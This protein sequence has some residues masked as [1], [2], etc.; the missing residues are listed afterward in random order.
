M[1]D[2]RSWS[3]GFAF[4]V[5]IYVIFMASNIYLQG[6]KNIYLQGGKTSPSPHPSPEYA[7]AYTGLKTVTKLGKCMMRV[8]KMLT[9]KLLM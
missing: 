7:G 3:N 4:I 8:Y 5:A 2:D 1:V 6:G 9:L